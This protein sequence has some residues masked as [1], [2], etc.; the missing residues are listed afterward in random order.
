[1]RLQLVI[2]IDSRNTFQVALSGGDV[3]WRVS[4][5]VH[6]G[7]GAARVQH[8]LCYIYVPCIRRPVET[9]VQLL[10]GKTGLFKVIT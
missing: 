6:R 1:M 9:H 3:E 5:H 10:R 7:E 4:V 8:Q 2:D